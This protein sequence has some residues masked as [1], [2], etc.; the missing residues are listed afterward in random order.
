LSRLDGQKI[1]NKVRLLQTRVNRVSFRD[2]D[3]PS[4]ETPRGRLWRYHFRV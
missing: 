4:K 3:C 1:L 2:A